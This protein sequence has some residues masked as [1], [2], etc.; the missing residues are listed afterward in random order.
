MVFKKVGIASDHAGTDLKKAVYEF[1]IQQ[2][3]E[4]I[5][6]G[7][8]IQSNQSVDY[9]DYAIPLA[10]DVS[11]KNIEGAIAICGTGIGMC[12]TANKFPK[13]RAC[14]VWD[15]YS[16]RMSREHNN[17]NF[18][19]IGSRTLTTHRALDIVKLWLDT[20]FSGGRHQSRLDKIANLEQKNF[21][22]Y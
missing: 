20:P 19:C 15:E 16:C 9:P 11:K 13:V 14:S 6:Y 12:I 21:N 10:K 22:I 1:L 18:L 4:A 3:I 17:S 5:D 7:V 8:D 2:G